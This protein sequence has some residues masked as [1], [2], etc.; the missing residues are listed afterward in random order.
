M[1]ADVRSLTKELDCLMQHS[2]EFNINSKLGHSVHCTMSQGPAMPGDNSFSFYYK[3]VKIFIYLFNP[4]LHKYKNKCT[5]GGLNAT[6]IFYQ[7]THRRCFYLL[8][9]VY[10]LAECLI[11]NSYHGMLIITMHHVICTNIVMLCNDTLKYLY[12]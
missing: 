8:I 6:S 5:K 1:K 4:L 7:S 3:K 11:V 10:L 9:C 12:S 2:T